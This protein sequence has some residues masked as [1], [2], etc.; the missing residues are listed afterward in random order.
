MSSLYLES[1]SAQAVAAYLS[2]VDLDTVDALQVART[3]RKNPSVVQPQLVVDCGRLQCLRT[4]GVG[5]V[6]SQLLVLR[7]AGATI[8]LCNADSTLRRC[9]DVLK[10]QRVFLT[11]DD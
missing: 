7:Q 10:L 5:H 9:L 11:I 1:S 8:W 3:L 4:L 6:V 2:A